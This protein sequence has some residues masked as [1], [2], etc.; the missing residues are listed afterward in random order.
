MEFLELPTTDHRF[1][2][3][4]QSHPEFTNRIEDPNPLSVGFVK[5]ARS[6]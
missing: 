6:L 3:A 4:T 5:A 2:V 1:F